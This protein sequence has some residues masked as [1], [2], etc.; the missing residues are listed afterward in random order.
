M[1]SK[2][3]KETELRIAAQRKAYTYAPPPIVEPVIGGIWGS[4]FAVGAI[5]ILSNLVGIEPGGTP[6]LVMI[7]V[8]ALLPMLYF[9]YQK[10]RHQRAASDE[11]ERLK[12][13]SSHA[14]P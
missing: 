14:K 6:M 2:S 5:A 13:E 4:L 3:S 12:K 8:L 7:A 9:G 10:W 11:F 1:S